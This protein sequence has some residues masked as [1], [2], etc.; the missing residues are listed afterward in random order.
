MGPSGSGKSTLLNVIGCPDRPTAGSYRLD[1]RE[2]AGLSDS[3]LAHIRRREIGHVFQTFYL[4]P[5]MTALEDVELGML[6]D[7][8]APRERRERALAA[9][10]HGARQRD[11]LV[12]GTT[13]E[14]L[15]LRG[16]SLASGEILP[17]GGSE[18]GSSVVVLGSKLP[19][20]L[21]PGQDPVGQTVRLGTW[22][23]RVV[24]TLAPRGT[25]LGVDLD[26]CVLVP[27]VTA[28]AMF[29]TRTLFRVML[30]SRPGVAAREEL[31]PIRALLRE[32]HGGE[33]DFTLIT[34]DA[35][36]AEIGSILD[37]LALALVAIAS[38]SL[39]VAGV[40]VA[41]AMLVAVSER[42]REVGL[43]KA[44]GATRADVP[45]QFLLEAAL[46]C[47]AG[48]LPGI[49]AGWTC[50]RAISAA[51]PAFSAPAPLWSVLASLAVSLATGLL[52]GSLPARSAMRLEA[53]TALGGRRT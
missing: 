24:G 18:R 28:Q 34:Q 27:V 38:I 14:M 26:E 11:V 23:L 42:T 32:R 41:N 37:M 47:V 49:G 52:A 5:R 3:E 45:P 20:E 50:A 44:L 8:V 7:A 2:V 53:V 40:G 9:L 6:F 39:V 30:E 48:G 22:R 25:H 35:V 46:L 33:E 10:A 19:R 21:F 31:E 16:M 1:G 15:G 36:L 29:D 4:V 17:V 13:T 12:L 51:F 43:C